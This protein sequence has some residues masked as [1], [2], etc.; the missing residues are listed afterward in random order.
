MITFLIGLGLGMT[1]VGAPLG[2]LFIGLES[3]YGSVRIVT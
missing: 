1:I 2:T 3:G